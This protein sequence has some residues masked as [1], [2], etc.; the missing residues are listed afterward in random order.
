MRAHAERFVHAHGEAM[1][2]AHERFVH[3][4]AVA[5]PSA[6]ATTRGGEGRT[7]ERGKRTQESPA[8][9]RSA[10]AAHRVPPRLGCAR[11]AQSK[12]RRCS[13]SAESGLLGE[14]AGGIGLA[15][16]P[17]RFGASRWIESADRFG[18][19]RY[20][21]LVACVCCV[22]DVALR[23]SLRIV[24]RGRQRPFR[25]FFRR[26]A[27]LSSS[28]QLAIAS[29]RNGTTAGLAASA[30]LALAAALR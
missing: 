2:R 17:E 16:V 11:C 12:P 18:R 8:N 30:A 14:A 6:H 24:L 19:A 4:N 25:N 7:R 28:A 26:F 3:T 20:C 15:V 1:H 27:T 5:T 10:P 22:T 23:M 29:L 13:G 21:G 9:R